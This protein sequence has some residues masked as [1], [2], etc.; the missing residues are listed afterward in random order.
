M[1][2]KRS[3]IANIIGVIFYV[4]SISAQTVYDSVQ[5]KQY[6][7]IQYEL[8]VLERADSSESFQ[9]FLA[10]TDSLFKQK[11][12]KLS[13]V[14]FGG[15]H[16]QADIYT[17]YIRYHLQNDTAGIKGARGM[18]FPYKTAKT[19]NPVNYTINQTGNWIGCRNALTKNECN[20]G[21]TGINASTTDSVASISVSSAN[22]FEKLY[23]ENLRIFYN[24]HCT[25][26]QLKLDYPQTVQSARIDSLGGFVE[27]TFT[28]PI[29]SFSFS[30]Q[31]DT[32]DSIPFEIYGMLLENNRPGIRYHAMGV[33]GA[34]TSS[35]NRCSM[36]EHQLKF[37]NPDL[38]ILSLGTNDT[39]D[40]SFT[41][42]NY[43]NSYDTLIQTIKRVNPNVAIIITVP[44]NS[45]VR[46]NSENKNL[47][48]AEQVIK[49]LCTKH[50]AVYWNFYRIMGGPKS[51]YTWYRN[52]IM[53]RDL[54]HFNREGYWIKGDLFYK[55]FMNS[56]KNYVER[57]T[58][59]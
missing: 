10:K 51:A 32:L 52:G 34:K 48:T 53:K 33:N 44:N 50:D 28:V 12:S 9:K 7:F 8:N 24:L 40:S 37:L 19:N 30:I 39:H 38:A 6:P 35:F 36:L 26:H 22:K 20:W 3:V 56:Y 58:T 59:K 11:K 16:I 5:I 46:K 1:F 41:A 2:S 15:S 4:H 57:T 49:D 21:V 18:I 14:H 17:D 47:S 13:I 25:T 23:I 54:V 42:E 43:Y 31:K 27:F 45:Y 29:D 55:A